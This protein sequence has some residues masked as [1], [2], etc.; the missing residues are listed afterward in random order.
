MKGG[1]RTHSYCK[2]CVNEQTIERQ[3]ALKLSAIE[4][5]GGVCH[6]CGKR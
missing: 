4:Y 2:K 6:D 3:R 1:K 5:N